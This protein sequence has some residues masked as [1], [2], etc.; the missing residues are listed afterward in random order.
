RNAVQT[1]S[2]D[3][4]LSGLRV[5]DFEPKISGSAPLEGTLNARAKLSGT[6]NSVHKAA[7]SADGRVTL[8]IPGG[9][10][11]QSFAELM[12]IDATK[13]LFMLLSKDPHQTDVRCAIADFSVSHGR[14]QLQNAVFDTGVVLVNGQGSI[15]LN[16]E[17][18]HMTFK[19]KPKKFRLIRIN[20][21]ILVGGHLSSPSFGI[22]AGP[23]VVQGGIGAALSTVAAPLLALPFIASGDEKNAN[24]AALMSE[25][26]SHG[27]PVAAHR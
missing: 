22:D 9:S 7:S 3:L 23:A 10:M 2:V 1:N 27:A 15:D 14:M 25:A 26:Q 11:R 19:G 13:G 5:Q 12:G 21:P 16:D 6:G 8:V 24:C 20:A 4:R 18:L 17:S